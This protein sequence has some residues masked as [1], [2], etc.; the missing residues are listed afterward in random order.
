MIHPTILLILQIM[1]VLMIV[2]GVWKIMTALIPL[3]VKTRSGQ[4]GVQKQY[5]DHFGDIVAPFAGIIEGMLSIS[6]Y[7]RSAIEGVLEQ[8]EIPLTPEQYEARNYAK[9]VAIIT[10]SA[11]FFFVDPFIAIGVAV[12]G[13]AYYDQQRGAV[14]RRITARREEIE[15]ELPAF[16]RFFMAAA[17]NEKR[18]ATIIRKYIS[19]EPD[20]RN[21]SALKFELNRAL[22]EMSAMS[23][24]GSSIEIAI[25]QLAK[26]IGLRKFDELATG[27][28]R[29]DRGEDQQTHFQFLE[30]D[31][32]ELALKRMERTAKRIPQ[33]I[34]VPVW[35]TLICAVCIIFIPFLMMIWDGLRGIIG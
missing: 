4:L 3:P 17:K 14:S 12:F 23:A 28:I 35:V 15:D 2:Y 30:R 10:A 34:A 29:M 25:N 16:T 13:L 33:Y 5:S 9:V 24:E 1:V 26:R 11:V 21:Y 19:Q 27:M 31:M 20:P 22:G 32:K 18:V 7:K 8:A 6:P